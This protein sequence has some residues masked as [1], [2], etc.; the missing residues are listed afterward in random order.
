LLKKQEN[1]IARIGM[2][3]AGVE[4]RLGLMKALGCMLVMIQEGKLIK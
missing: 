4:E 3:A 2:V 1:V